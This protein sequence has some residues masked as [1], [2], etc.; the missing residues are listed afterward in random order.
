MSVR[1]FDASTHAHAREDETAR[2]WNDLTTAL[3][4][5][6]GHRGH[7][8]CQ[9]DANAWWSTDA[10]ERAT[11]ARACTDCPV[12]G[13]CAAYADAAQERHGVW[14]GLDRTPRPGLK[15]RSTT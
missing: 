3:A 8:P 2:A 15:C 9:L 7:T 10:E 1:A 5:L 4:E 13:A 6:A 12:L 14:A 11:A